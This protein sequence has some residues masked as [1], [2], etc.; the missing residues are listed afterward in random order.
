[1]LW[2]MFQK[3]IMTKALPLL[4]AH[5]TE[6]NTQYGWDVSRKIICAVFI[7]AVSGGQVVVRCF[8]VWINELWSLHAWVQATWGSGLLPLCGHPSCIISSH[9]GIS[10]PTGQLTR[11]PQCHAEGHFLNSCQV[12]NVVRSNTAMQQ[13]FHP[14]ATLPKLNGLLFVW[15]TNALPR[16]Q[17]FGDT[18]SEQPKVCP[19]F[20][21]IIPAH[22]SSIECQLMLHIDSLSQHL[23]TGYHVRPHCA[24]WHLRLRRPT[25]SSSHRQASSAWHNQ[26]RTR[27]CSL[28]LWQVRVCNRGSGI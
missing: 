22:L 12:V 17:Q 27:K 24:I 15:G 10:F 16:G 20:F 26:L 21:I 1:M 9:A 14:V 11:A 3:L 7:C 8:V 5:L 4:A 25:S 2:S 18:S 23:V 6:Y 19:D 13:L 28:L